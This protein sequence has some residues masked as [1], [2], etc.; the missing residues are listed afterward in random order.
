VFTHR[1]AVN[2]TPTTNVAR[3]VRS[4]EPELPDVP[5]ASI[6]R[7]MLA[8][9]ID[10]LIL[11]VPAIVAAAAIPSSEVGFPVFFVLLIAGAAQ[12]VLGTARW[13]QSVGK[14]LMGI[15]VIE[16]HGH[17]PPD[18]WH[19]LLRWWLPTLLPPLLVWATWDKRRQGIHDRAA[20]TLVVRA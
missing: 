1:L 14:A 3:T 11:L 10:Y 15:R 9:L 8:R 6:P 20:E 4:A 17:G 19:A 18:L 16:E 7:R 2:S 5:L 12:D 13:G